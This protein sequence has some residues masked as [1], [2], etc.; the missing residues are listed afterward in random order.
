ML[1]SDA[2]RSNGDRGPDPGR[3][4]R[5]SYVAQAASD[6][7]WA[8]HVGVSWMYQALPAV[9]GLWQ[10]Q[11][12][13]DSLAFLIGSAAEY[14]DE[15]L[16]G[17]CDSREVHLLVVARDD[18]DTTTVPQ[19]VCPRCGEFTQTAPD[20]PDGDASAHGGPVEGVAALGVRLGGYSMP[21]DP[22]TRPGRLYALGSDP[23]EERIFVWRTVK[24]FARVFKMAWDFAHPGADPSAAAADDMMRDCGACLL[25]N[26]Q[27]DRLVG[28]PAR[29][30]NLETVFLESP[31]G[32]LVECDAWGRDLR[33]GCGHDFRAGLTFCS[34][35]VPVDA[36]T[37][38]SPTSADLADVFAQRPGLVA[39]SLRGWVSL[40]D[41]QPAWSRVTALAAF[42]TIEGHEPDLITAPP[43]AQHITPKVLQYR[44]MRA[45]MEMSPLNTRRALQPG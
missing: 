34:V 30:H 41:D 7:V 39:V 9:A 36:Q 17:G 8:D 45:L 19:A 23:G 26:A 5:S 15:R 21:P 18:P 31:N 27:T 20:P 37:Q 2:S 1:G 28:W 14:V 42:R 35:P 4:Q 10:T 38:H 25:D 16:L 33:S 13:R 6:G 12:E 43:Q 32:R 44:Q 40:A 24:R 22:A 29:S 3:F 11:H